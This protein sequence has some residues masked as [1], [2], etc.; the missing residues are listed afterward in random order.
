MLGGA[1]SSKVEG[2]TFVLATVALYVTLRKGV[3]RRSRVLARLL[4]PTIVALGLW[5]AFGH[6][7]QL[8]EGYEGYGEFWKIYPGALWNVL[9]SIGLALWRTAYGLPFLLPLLV[10]LAPA[11]T[12]SRRAG[13]PLGVAAAL[14]AFFVFTY[15]HQADA[16]QWIGWSAARI[17]SPLIPLFVLGAVAESAGDD[18]SPH[19]VSAAA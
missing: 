1:A 3:G 17:F 4:A 9:A 10:W 11:G 12:R 7:R 2:L 18:R 8:F 13:L 16:A 6:V 5:F 15:L 19:A 14:T